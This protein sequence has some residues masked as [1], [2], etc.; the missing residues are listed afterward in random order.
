MNLTSIENKDEIQV[1]PNPTTGRFTIDLGALTEEVNL[2]IYNLHG[3]LLED[4]NFY[5]Q[6]QI[7][8][9]LDFPPAVYLL[10]IRKGAAA[11]KILKLIKN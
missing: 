7:S 6:K 8:L 5:H 11:A 9:R 4:Q 3:Q 10:K 1:Y 2:S